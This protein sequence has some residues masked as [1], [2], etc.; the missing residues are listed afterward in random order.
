MTETLIA[1]E[2]VVFA[3]RT[4]AVELEAGD[5]R[6]VDVRIA[7]YGERIR[8]NDGLGG[9]PAGM[10]YEEEILPGAFDHQVN[11]AHRVLANVEHE[12]GIGGVVGRGLAL[13]S[14]SDG[15]YG[16]FR[17]LDTPAGDTALELVREKALG[18]VSMEA[19]FV[20]SIRTAEGVVQRVKANLRNIALC[21]DPAYSGALVLGLREA[22]EEI[23]TF[24]QELGPEFLPLPFD[25]ALA[26]RIE[27]LGIDVPSRL[28]NGHLVADTSSADDTSAGDTSGS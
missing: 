16:S 11:A 10:V 18:G 21:R 17:M 28:K 12:Q 8:A 4:Y 23:E 27:R 15:F 19:R 25:Q 22:D 3:R 24:V 13:R 14:A 6:T 1:P 26:E 7:P 20:K 5:G 9:L 2:Q